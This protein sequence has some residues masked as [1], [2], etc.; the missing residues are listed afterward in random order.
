MFSSSASTSSRGSASE[1]GTTGP[2]RIKNVGGPDGDDERNDF[3]E[4]HK[5]QAGIFSVLYVLSK[6]KMNENLKFTV[7]KLMFDFTQ[8]HMC[9]TGALKNTIPACPNINSSLPPP[10]LHPALYSYWQI[11]TFSRWNYIVTNLLGYKAYVAILYT[12]T[13]MLCCSLALCVWIAYSYK[14]RS[15]A[16]T[17]PTYVLRL[18]A[19]IH[20]GLFDIATLTLI[21]VSYDCQ[22]LGSGKT[23]RGRMYTFPDRVCY[24]APH[25]IPFSVGVVTQVLFVIAAVIFFTGEFEVNPIS[26]RFTCCAH[27]H[28]EVR[29]F[30]LKVA[31][32]V[33]YVVMGWL[34]VQTTIQAF[35]C[36]ALTWIFFKNMPYMFAIINHIRVGSYLAVT[37]AAMLAVAIMFK[38]KEP[39]RMALYEKRITNVMLYGLAPIALLG[40]GASFLRLHTWSQFVR[41]RFKE[42]PSGSKVKDIYRFKDPIEVEIISRVARHWIDDEVLDLDRVKEA[43]A[44]IKAGLVLFPTRAF[45]IMLYSNFLWDVLDNPQAGYSQLQAAKKANPNYMERFAI[46]RREQEHLA[47]TAQ[48]KGNGES[49]LDLVSYVEFQR[50]YRLAMRAHREALLATR[51][52]WQYLLQQHITF[53]HLSKSL[54]AIESAIMKVWLERG[55]GGV[56]GGADKVYRTVLERYPYSAKMIKGYAR[57]LEGVKNDPWRASKFYTEAEKLEAEREEE[58]AALELEGLDG[59]DSR[60]LNKVDERVNA[61][62]IINSRGQIQ[63]ANKLAYAMFGYNKGELEGKNVAML[64]PLPF[65]QRHNGYIKRHIT[66]GRETVMN[67]VTDLVALH[68]DRYVFPFRLAVSKV[69]GAGDDSLFM[70]VI[71]AVEPLQDTANVYI[72]PGGSVAA[73]DQAFVD[74]FGYTVEDYLGHPVH[75][76]AVDP[77]PFKRLVEEVT[78]NDQ[79]IEDGVCPAFLGAKHALMKHKYTDPVDVSLH[80]KATGLGSETIYRVEMRRNQPPVELV[81]TNRK[82]RIAFITS[83]LAKAMGHTPR[84][85]RKVDIGELLPQPFGAMHAAWIRE[86][87]E[88]KPSPH[89]CRS[90]VTMV[91]GPTPKTQQTVRLAIK[92]TDESGEQQHVVKVSPSTMSEGLDERRLRLTID[93]SGTVTDVGHSPTSLFGFKPAALLG[94]SLADCV[95]V[96]HAA[97]RS[98]S[99][100]AGLTSAGGGTAGGAAADA[101]AAAEVRRIITLLMGRALERPG[102]SWRVGVMPPLENIRSLGSIATALLAKQTRP[103]VMELDVK[104]DLED[105]AAGREVAINISLWRADLVCGVLEVDKEGVVLTSQ[106]H[107]FYPSGLLFG[108]SSPSVLRQPLGRFVQ[109]GGRTVESLF[110]SE[111]KNG[112]K[113]GAL[114]SSSAASK[115]VGPLRNLGAHHTDGEALTLTVQAVRKEGANS[116]FFVVLHFK[117]P[118]RGSRDFMALLQRGPVEPR[119]TQESMEMAVVNVVTSSASTPVAASGKGGDGS[120]SKST[121]KLQRGADVVPGLATAATGPTAA[122]GLVRAVS[123]QQQPA[124]GR[125][126]RLSPAPPLLSPSPPGATTVLQGQPPSPLP[127]TP[128]P[129]AETGPMVPLQPHVALLKNSSGSNNGSGGSSGESLNIS[130]PP[131]DESI[132]QAHTEAVDAAVAVNPTAAAA[133]AAT[134]FAP[135]GLPLGMAGL[136]LQDYLVGRSDRSEDD[137]ATLFDRVVSGSGGGDAGGGPAG[138]AARQQQQLLQQQR[139][140]VRRL[141]PNMRPV[142]INNLS[143]NRRLREKLAAEAAAAA[144]ASGSGS[145]DGTGSEPCAPTG[146]ADAA[147]TSVVD[148]VAASAASAALVTLRP[149]SPVSPPP[150]PPPP[151]ALQQALSL[152]PPGAVHH[153]TQQLPTAAAGLGALTAAVV[154]AKTPPPQM[155]TAQPQPQPPMAPASPLVRPPLQATFSLPP[156][157]TGMLVVEPSPTPPP[158]PAAASAH[159]INVIA[160][161]GGSGGLVSGGGS[162]GSAASANLPMP[163]PPPLQQQPP[164]RSAS[165][166]RTLTMQRSFSRDSVNS[167]TGTN[168]PGRTSMG[169]DRGAGQSAAAAAT[170][171]SPPGLVSTA[172][173]SVRRSMST[174]QVSFAP[175]QLLIDETGRIE[176]QPSLPQLTLPPR[177]SG[178]RDGGGGG[179]GTVPQLLEGIPYDVYG[180]ADSGRGGGGGGATGGPGG[181]RLL[182]HAPQQQYPYA[183]AMGG[184]AAQHLY[185][186]MYGNPYGSGG[187]GIGGEETFG[188]A[189]K[190]KSN[191]KLARIREWVLSE[192]ERYFRLEDVQDIGDT[193]YPFGPDLLQRDDSRASHTLVL[194]GGAGEG[195]GDGDDEEADAAP[196]RWAEADGADDANDMQSLDDEMLYSNMLLETASRDIIRGN[197]NA[198]ADFRRGKR[199]RK[200]L[201]MLSTPAVQRATLAF[202]WQ[203]LLAIAVQLLANLACFVLLTVLLI[204]QTRGLSE[205]NNVGQALVSCHDAMLTLQ[206]LLR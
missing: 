167:G 43:E 4:T 169:L 89:S 197:G 91:L 140:M 141:A 7:I 93:T 174:K 86:A 115:K 97:A 26:R 8:Q 188:A 65:S 76:L 143:F 102:T 203:A 108:V 158:L 44:I 101:M 146:D 45:M 74:W 78:R 156:S 161:S 159:A 62:I 170:L 196:S 189:G 204:R 42:A 118:T 144:I 127:G 84:S 172:G 85:L 13:G 128:M 107:P 173:Q 135:P 66:T 82:G 69:S 59:D 184:A 130:T 114:K 99:A 75:T 64:M 199:C 90:G 200:L 6:E 137:L 183:A 179:G 206:L 92:S 123:P 98:A 106:D 149:G 152:P 96:L 121:R 57:F 148:A 193:V 51:N 165:D 185:G 18:Y 194:N 124:D 95:D 29:A 176:R 10:P 11:L 177:L 19:T 109:L 119:M 134:A 3:E 53:T 9:S 21:Q 16:Y 154:R 113:K 175:S 103:A 25:L 35:L 68:K 100:S 87:A 32:T 36:L 153:P 38:P 50:N 201:K 48:T 31:M 145:G 191:V 39:E 49:T 142:G 150:L 40:F 117:E 72:L 67:R 155:A 2:S 205:L 116:R 180:D 5:I 195:D 94:R 192:G 162:G 81:L 1:E 120:V 70:G 71:M 138:Q 164:L 52:F 33:V 160:S 34:Q 80:L 202:R 166:L 54:K 79:P 22:F 182:A 110:L 83:P 178:S 122:V 63:M 14:N 126:P 198:Q 73:V 41:K 61:V 88:S 131:Q 105:L 171:L 30:L 112:G 163:P 37:W 190:I 181:A 56:A 55:G 27:S 151:L 17:W 139:P 24:E 46:Y 15:F 168:N 104:V 60:L 133:A 28:V 77:M 132:S 129:S 20:F 58:A 136:T 147:V 187:L 186:G 23:N 157:S 125:S 47:R 111:Y 12:M